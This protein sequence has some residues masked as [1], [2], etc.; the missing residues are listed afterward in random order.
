MGPKFG[1]MQLYFLFD[2]TVLEGNAV[3]NVLKNKLI[4]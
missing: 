4:A 2:A 3:V 1:D